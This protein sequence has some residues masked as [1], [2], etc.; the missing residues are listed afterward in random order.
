MLWDVNQYEKFKADRTR[1]FYD[2][3][4]WIDDDDINEGI[5]LGCGT[6][7]VTSML[8]R[9]VKVGHMTGI[10]TSEEML[11]NTYEYQNK[12]L[13]FQQLSIESWAE[14]KSL[15]RYD[16]IFSNAALQWCDDHHILLPQIISHL[17]ER[18]QLAIQMP[19]QL[20][21]AL[22]RILAQLVQRS[23]YSDWL[24]GWYRSSPLLCMD[25]YAQILYQCGLRNIEIMQKVYPIEALDPKTLIEFISGSSLRPYQS[26]LS[27]NQYDDLIEEYTS[28]IEKYFTP[29]P[30][31][32]AFKRLLLYGRKWDESNSVH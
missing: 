18:G 15:H 8:V 23:P 19:C 3:I 1:P 13:S 11:K 12:A 28:L 6:G 32:Y 4:S 27:T 31:L 20:D 10:D 30:T 25:A 24:S 21:N 29:F 9:H 5:D 26:R 22:N 2:L 7:E 17:S 16:L 14:Q